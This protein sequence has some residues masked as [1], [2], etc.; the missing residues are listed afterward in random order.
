MNLKSVSPKYYNFACAI[1]CLYAPVWACFV[2]KF[3]YCNVGVHDSF[4]RNLFFIVR[5]KGGYRNQ[6][7]VRSFKIL[8]RRGRS[9]I[10]LMYLTGEDIYVTLYG[11]AVDVNVRLDKNTLKLE[12]TFISCTS[13]RWATPH[14]CEKRAAMTSMGRV[15]SRG[16]CLVFPCLANLRALKNVIAWLRSWSAD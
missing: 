6:I 11:A 14:T 8:F 2:L 9:W 7:Y 1:P 15:E 4:F 3:W 13:Q 5:W 10:L 16:G 12:N